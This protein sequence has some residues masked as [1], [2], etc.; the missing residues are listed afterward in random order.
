MV[1][2]PALT[3]FAIS[4]MLG[5]GKVMLIGNIIEQEFISSMNWKLGAALSLVLMIVVI[6]GLFISPTK[7]EEQN[8]IIN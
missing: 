1:F 2:V 4:D 7:A 3:T 5:G 8:T 6:P